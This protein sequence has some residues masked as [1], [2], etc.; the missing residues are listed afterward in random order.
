MGKQRHRP[1]SREHGDKRTVIEG[2][3]RIIAK[4]HYKEEIMKLSVFYFYLF[5]SHLKHLII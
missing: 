1:S 2:N 5:L 3:A 4:E